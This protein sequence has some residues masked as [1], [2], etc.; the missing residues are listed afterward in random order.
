MSSKPIL[1]VLL[2]L[3]AAINSPAQT[4]GRSRPPAPRPAQSVTTQTATTAD[5]RKVVLKSDGTW[6]YANDAAAERTAPAEPAKE[7]GVLSL[8]AGLVYRSGD[9][10]PVARTEF[11][12][13][14]QDLVKILEDAGVKPKEGSLLARTAA[15]GNMN[16]AFALA[17]KYN[18]LPDNQPFYLAAMEA[19][20]PH[21]LKTV[22]TDFSGK[23]NFEAVPAGTY[24]LMGLASTPRG[25]AFWSMPVEIKA[26]QTSI[27]LDQNNAAYAQ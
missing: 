27:V 11:H 3:T 4:R 12:L 23:A 6:E 9:V 19:I 13:L 15:Q 22:T 20:K 24:H 1:A 17:A 2:V 5:G 7:N 18:S 16:F 26:G 21:I 25:F 14:D 8:E 10:K